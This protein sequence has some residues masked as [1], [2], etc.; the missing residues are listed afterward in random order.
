MGEKKRRVVVT[1]AGAISPNGIGAGLDS[2]FCQNTVAGISGVKPITR[3][4]RDDL[5][6]KVAA[7]IRDLDIR[8]YGCSREEIEP[9]FVERDLAPNQAFYYIQPSMDPYSQ[10]ALPAAHFAIQDS[11]LQFGNENPYR[12]GVYI[13]TAIGGLTTYYKLMQSDAEGSIVKRK[14]YSFLHALPSTAPSLIAMRYNLRGPSDSVN[15]AC[16]SGTVGIIQAYEQIL[17]GNADVVIAGGAECLTVHMLANAA[18]ALEVVA[19]G[20]E[21]EPEKASRPFDRD[22]S[23]FVIGEG[24]G[25][26]ILESLE[27]AK[28]RNAKIYAEIV[29]ASIHNGASNMVQPSLET[30]CYVM[31]EA[32]ERA[33][34]GIRQVGYINAHGTSTKIGDEIE[35]AAMKKVFKKYAREVPISSTKSMVGH[36]FGAAGALESIVCTMVLRDQIIPPTINLDNPDPNCDLFY[37]PNKAIR[38]VR[39]IQ[40]V[41]NNSFGMGD[42]NAAIVFRRFEG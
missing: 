18:Q 21:T 4:R 23:G 38:P 34:I 22:R 35:T 3:F 32:L 2:E 29:G 8:R 14:A 6:V 28:N 20:Y 17:L 11:G 40:F 36:T 15:A 9:L 13:G 41:L 12:I 1:G 10:F 39:P 5:E 26:L 7:E 42:Y 19:R 16:A 27:H 25:I 31:N 37:V 30:E 24:A 33:G